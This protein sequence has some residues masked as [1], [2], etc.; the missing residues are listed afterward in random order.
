[1]QVWA[2]DEA[3]AYRV[4]RHACDIGGWNFEEELIRVEVGQAGGSRNGRTGTMRTKESPL[5]VEVTKRDG[6]SG[7]PSIG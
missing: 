2:E 3:E 7:F 5:G 6:P 4:I 1:M